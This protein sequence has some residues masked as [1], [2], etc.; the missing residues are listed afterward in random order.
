MRKKVSTEGYGEMGHWEK[1]PL[2]CRP[3]W[4][5]EEGGYDPQERYRELVG[6]M[7]RAKAFGNRIQEKWWEE[8][9]DLV[10][11]IY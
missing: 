3:R 7:V 5:V 10:H 1:P 11:R 2:G 4:L 8:Y 9:V 6:A